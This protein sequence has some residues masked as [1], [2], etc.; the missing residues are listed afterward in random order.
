VAWRK[1]PT[2]P[3][4]R[5][6][7][8]KWFRSRTAVTDAQ[9][10]ALERRAKLTAFTISGVT[11]LNV[12]Q[13]ALNALAAAVKKGDDFAGFQA[14]LKKKLRDDFAQVDSHRLKTTF[15][16]QT[17]TALNVGRWEQLELG[18][19]PFR[20]YW[21][22]LD[23]GTTKLCRSLHRTVVRAN[24]PGLLLMWPPLHHGC[25]LGVRGVSASTA[26]RHG[27]SAHIK[28]KHQPQPGFGYAPPVRAELELDRSSYD[29]TAL[30]QHEQKQRARRKK[31]LQP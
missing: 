12:V 27:V 26:S 1:V 13:A 29:P 17:Q 3:L 11:Q 7:A 22:V 8:V 15:Q 14:H 21:A 23:S 5:R 30:A 31:T 20:M 2:S 24:N 25:R 9:Y 18:Q 4:E 6:A 10:A 16:T 19:K 28:S